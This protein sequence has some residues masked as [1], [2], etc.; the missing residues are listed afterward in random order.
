MVIALFEYRLRADIDVAEWDQTFARM[1]ALAS[2]MPGCISIDGYAS[3]DG[4]DLAV[5]RFE[6]EETLQAW[7]NHPEHVLAQG[8]GREEFFDTYKVTVASPVTREYGGQRTENA[9]QS[10]AP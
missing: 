8:R 1:V 2:E 4:V 3:P 6:S 5:V 7:K 9:A 10:S